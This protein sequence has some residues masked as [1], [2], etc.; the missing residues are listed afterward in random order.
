M[1]DSFNEIETSDS[2]PSKKPDP[3]VYKNIISRLNVN[4]KYSVAIEDTPNGLQSANCAGL[5]TIVTVHEMT[6]SRLPKCCA[7][8]RFHW[9]K[10][11]AIQTT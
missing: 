11:E 10:R 5:T 2:T 3:Q 8:S 6:K 7:G 1:Q 4:P 9:N